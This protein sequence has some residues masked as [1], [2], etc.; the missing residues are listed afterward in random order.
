MLHGSRWFYLV[1]LNH[2]DA[3]LPAE[4]GA[5]WWKPIQSYPSSGGLQRQLGKIGS[6][7]ESSRWIL[8]LLPSGEARY[9]CTLGV[10]CCYSWCCWF[11]P[12]S[13]TRG[14]TKAHEPWV[15]AD[16]RRKREP[17]ADEMYVMGNIVSWLALLR[18]NSFVMSLHHLRRES[19]VSPRGY[20]ITV[21]RNWNCIA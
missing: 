7:S 21:C 13:L 17:A 16:T 4:M 12:G 11:G 19:S 9:W 2:R 6:G 14:W 20:S 18:C 1:P 15:K 3:F 8:I 10:V 5:E